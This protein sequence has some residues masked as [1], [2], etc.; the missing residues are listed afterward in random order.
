VTAAVCLHCAHSQKKHNGN[1][2]KKTRGK[3]FPF[4]PH[5]LV[6]D[7]TIVGKESG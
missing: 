4:L 1:I 5:P 2:E 6:G 3:K 7:T